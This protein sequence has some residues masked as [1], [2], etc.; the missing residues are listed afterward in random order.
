MTALPSPWWEK[1]PVL[2]A[3]CIT[4]NQMHFG[5]AVTTTWSSRGMEKRTSR[6]GRPKWGW[7]SGL[8]HTHPLP[9]LL[10]AQHPCD[11]SAHTCTCPNSSCNPS[12]PVWTP[13]EST[14][15]FAHGQAGKQETASVRVGLLCLFEFNVISTFL[16]AKWMSQYLQN[17]PTEIRCGWQMTKAWRKEETKWA[18][19]DVEGPD[20]K[21]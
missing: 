3:T 12:G 17:A 5:W 4:D 14:V 21:C 7:G 18:K 10:Q 19:S 6:S 13:L 8:C 15:L 16:W 1:E 11:L 2:T 20:K 9:S